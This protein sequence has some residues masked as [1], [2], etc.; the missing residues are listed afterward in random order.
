MG[1]QG[2][3][4]SLSSRSLP[5]VDQCDHISMTNFDNHIA[6]VGDF[7]PFAEEKISLALKIQGGITYFLSLAIGLPC[8][9]GIAH[10][11][12]HGG[13]P[14]KRMLN[15]QLMTFGGLLTSIV[16]IQ[17]GSV[18]LS[19]ALFGPV[20]KHLA[21]INILVQEMA[22]IALPFNLTQI[23]AFHCL[24]LF[25]WRLATGINDDFMATYLPLVSIMFG[26]FT[27]G[28]TLILGL[29]YDERYFILSGSPQAAWQ[30]FK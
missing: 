26:L 17:H 6:D 11:E 21:L 20:G 15:N 1:P 7:E 29:F 13:D 5:H 16:L 10:Y 3:N 30:M 23:L 24:R 9:L 8:T 27:S 19:R 12:R 4:N 18:I 14:H 25:N 28:S 22:G 2:L